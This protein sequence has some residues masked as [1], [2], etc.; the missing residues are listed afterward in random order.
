MLTEEL[1]EDGVRAVRASSWVAW[2]ARKKAQYVSSRREDMDWEEG[3][4]TVRGS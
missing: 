2:A 3:G 4:A 1:M